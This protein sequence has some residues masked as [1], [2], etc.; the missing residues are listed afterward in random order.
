MRSQNLQKSILINLK[1]LHMKR[2]FTLFS[3]LSLFFS[4][5]QAQ[6]PI[7]ETTPFP[8]S[9]LFA[10]SALLPNGNVLAWGGQKL[11]QAPNNKPWLSKQ[12]YVYDPTTETWSAGPDLNH[13]VI[14]PTVVTLANGNIMSMG[15]QG[16]FSI[17]G[18]DSFPQRTHTVEMYDFAT[19]SW[20]EMDTIPF[21]DSPYTGTSGV[22]TSQ[23]HVWF[24]STNGDYA[25]FKTDSMKW[26]PLTGT[27]GPLDAGGSPMVVLNNGNV[28]LSG[29]GG[30]IW[31]I[32]ANNLT[33]VDPPLQIYSQGGAVIKLADGRILTWDHAFA[34]S[35]A[36]ALV[37]ATGNTS[38]F[39]DSLV[40]PGQAVT[41]VLMPDDKVWA[42][43]LGEP[44]TF[45]PLTLLQ[46]Y[47]PATETWSS[48]G[49][50]NFR[51]EVLTGY[52]LHLLQ[53]SSVLVLSTTQKSYR[54]NAG[55]GQTSIERFLM[56]LYWDLLYDDY[57]NVLHIQP[58]TQAG[59]EKVA[60]SLLDLQGKV[61]QQ[62]Q[63][64]H[65]QDFPLAGLPHGIY[66]ARL[67]REDG[68]FVYRKIRVE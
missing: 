41:G 21:G 5:A 20:M 4:L 42:F 54:I 64:S 63:L 18:I 12:S 56:P 3:I 19:N 62:A 8:D 51:P 44:L 58:Q 15:G 33:Y 68:A 61:L 57:A 49:T 48:P 50:Y 9:V 26:Q 22:L 59:P 14:S 60:F 28:F 65:A 23:D 46:I 43:G 45:D 36:A 31:D 66:I 47:D 7:R 10:A 11:A 6:I 52:K 17:V 29:A 2:I 40:I 67:H 55:A 32:S 30:Q 53:D 35:Q 1:L 27:L 25:L 16:Y 37:S 24:T 13:E 38:T 39:T 34:F